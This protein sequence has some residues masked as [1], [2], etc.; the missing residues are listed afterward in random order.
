MSEYQ[1]PQIPEGINVSKE[2]PLKDFAQMAVVVLV[3]IILAVSL[4][5]SL[6]NFLLP[7][8]PL[9][10]ELAIASKVDGLIPAQELSAETRASQS[11]QKQQLQSL[12]D[13]LR[14]DVGLPADLPVTVHLQSDDLVNAFATLGGHLIF[15]QGLLDALESESALAFVVAHELAHLKERHPLLALG[16]GIVVGVSLATFVGVSDSQVSKF[17]MN[18]TGQLTLFSFNREMETAADVIAFQALEKNYGHLDG[19]D[20]LFQVFAKQREVPAWMSTHPTSKQRQKALEARAET[21]Q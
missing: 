5:V 2:H 10:V 17:I 1:N 12:V 13:E 16:R 3:T 18:T 11:S 20:E 15:H 19:V 9:S 14:D 8:I 7:Y 21:A 6:S 4:L